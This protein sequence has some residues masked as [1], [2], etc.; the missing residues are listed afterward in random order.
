MIIT[1]NDKSNNISALRTASA[2]DLAV[3]KVTSVLR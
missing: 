3:K 2:Y 1:P